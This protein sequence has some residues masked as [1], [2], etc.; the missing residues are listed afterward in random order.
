MTCD[1]LAYVGAA[2]LGVVLAF[3]VLAVA[4]VM[5]ILL[6]AGASVFDQRGL[7]DKRD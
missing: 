1:A 5:A 4:F 6:D 7:D 3:G 2:A